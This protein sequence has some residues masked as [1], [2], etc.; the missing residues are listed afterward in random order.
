MLQGIRVEDAQWEEMGNGAMRLTARLN[1][2]DYKATFSQKSPKGRLAIEK[3]GT[4]MTQ[5]DLRQFIE[6]LFL[7]RYLERNS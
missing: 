5:E 1:G 3:G 2:Q 4:K 7:S 6:N